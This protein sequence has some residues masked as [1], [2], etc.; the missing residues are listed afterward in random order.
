M[1]HA[2][3]AATPAQTAETAALAFDAETVLFELGS[4]DPYWSYDGARP[5]LRFTFDAGHVVAAFQDAPARGVTCAPGSFIVLTPGMRVRTRH[6]SPIE[7]L[8]LTFGPDALAG[9]PDLSAS[10]AA[11]AGD[12]PVRTIDPGVWTLAVEA[13]RVLV[14]EPC[15]DRGYMAALGEAMLARA[16]QVIGQ[17]EAPRGRA[18]ISPF[19]LRRV[20]DHVEARLDSKI[21][22]RELAVLAE[23]SAAHFTRAFRQATGEAPHHFILSRRITRV[24]EL[25][26]DPALD[27]TTVA[28]RAGFSSHAHMTSA[29]RRLTGL[30]PAAYRA[31]VSAR[32]AG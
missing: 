23:L 30:A 10:L 26:R 11:I 3:E 29:F 24:R 32:L 8:A 6:Q 12:P 5:Q 2:R 27:L 15:P 17:G 22:V 7:I 16:L 14:G 21:T 31:A 1:S 9:R 13:R 25:L 18:S 20:I 28:M 19:R 4:V